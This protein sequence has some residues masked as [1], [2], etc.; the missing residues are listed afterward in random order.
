MHCYFHFNYLIFLDHFIGDRTFQ[1][2]LRRKHVIIT[3]KVCNTSKIELISK[4][5]SVYQM[6]ILEP[7]NLGSNAKYLIKY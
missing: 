7:E 5:V 1:K 6:S 3:M 2:V 4:G